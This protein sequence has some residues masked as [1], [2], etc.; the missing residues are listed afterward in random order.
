MAYPPIT[1]LGTVPQR[2]QTPAE[3]ATNAD[4][5]L[6][7]LPNFRTELN[8][9]GAYVDT[10][11]AEVDADAAA[12]ANSALQS[13][14]SASASDAS[15]ALALSYKDLAAGT[16]N[17]KGSWSALTGALAVPASVYHNGLTWV[18]LSNLAN[19][20]A[21]EPGISASW[22][23]ASGE[24]YQ[25]LVDSIFKRATLDLDFSA[26]SHK[27]YE[28][29]GLEPKQ[30]QSVVVTARNSTATYQSPTVI[31]TAAINAPRITYDA[32]TGNAL[33]LLV[34]EQ[35]TNLLL[36]SQEF[37]NA[38]W[39]Q[40][41]SADVDVTAN[42]AVAPDG[43]STADK[44][45][46]ATTANTFH[47]LFQS[48]TFVAGAR[49]TASAFVKASERHR[50]ALTF[51]SNAGFTS[52]RLVQFN[53]V[54]KTASA[55][56]TGAAAGIEEYT[57]GWFRVWV[58]ATADASGASPFYF[59]LQDNSGT[60]IYAGTPSSGLF[61]WGAQIEAGAAP[62]SYIPTT[63]AQ[64]TR[65]ADQINAAVP[66]TPE[67]TIVCVSCGADGVAGVN[68]SAF[69]LS[70]GTSSNRI[71]LRR[72]NATG[73]TQYLVVSV[74]S[75]VAQVNTTQK[76]AGQRNKFAISW[77]PNQFLGAEDGLVVL[78]DTS[79]NAPVGLTQLGIGSSGSA[80]GGAESLNGAVERIVFIP[81]ALTAAELQAVT[82]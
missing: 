49:Y 8:T 12:A 7:A 71:V 15:A 9:F 55:I 56:G 32:T 39:T 23:V 64:V 21:A 43:T 50:G 78:N 14:N 10:K 16:A 31:T 69:T 75:N 63:T 45:I 35:R 37:D 22:V 41:P 67:G 57:N 52:E 17:F 76:A 81:R 60:S 44:M 79:G 70:D 53:L 47:D 6:G 3:F 1:S 11:G 42:A 73:G 48:L 58:S 54:A 34:E 24:S 61:I 82:A 72:N 66:V 74:G 30:L 20:T 27:V 68:Q 38:S 51:G 65:L 18:L 62:T 33:G 13:Q 36:R 40:S 46:E 26:N 77:K 2:T 59:R 28:Q 5:F 29:F 19:V 80:F 4:S 25:R